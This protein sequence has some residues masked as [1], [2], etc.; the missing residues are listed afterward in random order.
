MAEQDYSQLL[1]Q[2]VA[3]LPW[4]HDLLL[5]NHLMLPTDK[6]RKVITDEIQRF[7]AECEESR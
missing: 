5:L 1:R 3:G 4:S 2:A 6:L 7:D